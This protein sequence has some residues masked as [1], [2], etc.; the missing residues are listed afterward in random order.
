MNRRQ[1]RAAVAKDGPSSRPAPSEPEIPMALP[2]TSSPNSSTRQAKTLYEIA[3]E[4]QAELAPHGKPFPK[5]T[6]LANAAAPEP[7]PNPPP[8]AEALPPL[9]DTLLLSFPLT[10]LHF[11]LT[12]LTHHQYAPADH[13]SLLSLLQ[14]S[15]LVAFP[16]LTLLIHTAHGHALPT[17]TITSTAIS[18]A[19][20][21]AQQ[22]AFIITANIAGCYLIY[23]TNDRGYYAVMKR[24]PAIGTLWVWCVIELGLMGALA[25][26]A[27]P[28]LF[29]W[30]NGYGVF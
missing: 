22:L 3:A 27:G 13:L 2:L 21:L 29:A 15:L 14:Q 18:T 7:A 30:W 5:A 6:K 17:S 12:F 23:L 11:T 16:T 4:R 20:K 25:G 26:V 8:Q 9:L 19:T 24:A 28:A 1:R 10:S